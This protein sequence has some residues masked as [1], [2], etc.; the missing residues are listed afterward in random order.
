M[1][2]GSKSPNIGNVARTMMIADLYGEEGY[3]TSIMNYV[4]NNFSNVLL[5][6]GWKEVAKKP[7]TLICSDNFI[8]CKLDR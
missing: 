4:S 8:L 1:L 7:G 5:S 2:E 6:D 3:K